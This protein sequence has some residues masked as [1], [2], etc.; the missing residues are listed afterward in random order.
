M[1]HRRRRSP[2]GSSSLPSRCGHTSRRSCASSTCRRAKRR[3][4]CSSVE[5]AQRQTGRAAHAAPPGLSHTRSGC[6]V[7]DGSRS[8]LVP[9]FGPAP[10][11]AERRN[12]VGG[13][14]TSGCAG[15]RVPTSVQ[16]YE[17]KIGLRALVATGQ[18]DNTGCPGSAAARFCGHTR[19]SD[20]QLFGELQPDRRLVTGLTCRST[21]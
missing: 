13:P 8:S 17:R 14:C 18:R 10:P 5:E 16:S 15:L 3:S 21:I 2:R 19:E 20:N 4:S 11:A 6:S 1:G 9:R 7:P 12:P